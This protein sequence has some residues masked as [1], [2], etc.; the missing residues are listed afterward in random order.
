MP[1]DASIL[2]DDRR[3]PALCTYAVAVL[4]EMQ[5]VRR[6]DAEALKQT[7]TAENKAYRPMRSNGTVTIP[8]RCRFIGT[9]NETVEGLVND[10]TGARRFYDIKC[11]AKVDWCTVNTLSYE[12]LWTA[13]SEKSPCPLA[14]HLATVRERQ[15]ELK[16]QDSVSLWA[17]AEAW[18]VPKGALAKGMTDGGDWLP[19]LAIRQL[20]TR[21]C[22]DH[23]DQVMPMV[24]WGRRLQ[25]LGFIPGRQRFNN[26][27]F[28]G[29]KLPN[30]ASYVAV[31]AS[32]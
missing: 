15:G 22:R 25:A 23:T 8:V 18:E 17:A 6:A 10:T 14:A 12:T 29:Y 5:G 16:R 31:D 26:Q 7:I 3:A 4:D 13:I 9:T 21:Y 28:Y 1:C 32:F 27:R 24:P 19:T 11:V 20:Y 2:T 30:N